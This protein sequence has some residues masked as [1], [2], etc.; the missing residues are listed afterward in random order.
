MIIKEKHRTAV[1]E[2]KSSYEVYVAVV[3]LLGKN[4]PPYVLQTT[5]FGTERGIDLGH[6]ATVKDTKAKVLN[7]RYHYLFSFIEVIFS[8][9]SKYHH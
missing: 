3:I 9:C 4:Q 2:I 6:C 8:W 1:S 5:C 7:E